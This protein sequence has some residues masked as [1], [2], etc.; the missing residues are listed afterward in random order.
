MPGESPWAIVRQVG[1][2]N[3][4]LGEINNDLVNSD[5]HGYAC[6]DLITFHLVDYGFAKSWEPSPNR[7][8]DITLKVTP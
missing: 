4:F 7:K 6:G 8:I 1:E 3:L 2:N 5:E